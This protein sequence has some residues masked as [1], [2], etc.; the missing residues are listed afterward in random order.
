MVLKT[1]N[2]DAFLARHRRIGLDTSIFIYQVEAHPKYV[3]TTH[4]IFDWLEGPRARA[5]TSTITMLELLVHPYR[6]SDEDR[7]N[8]FYALLSTY[9]HL[10]WIDTTLGI[11]D[12]AAQLRADYGLRTPDAVQAA[13]ALAL[14][15]TGFISNDPAF[16]RIK[17]LDV[18]I[19]EDLLRKG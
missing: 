14:P 16:K 2:I 3:E 18:V 1:S 17:E 4:Q 19:L 15:A 10:E 9:P 11:A 8:A 5:A 12:R 7:V 6:N 13:S